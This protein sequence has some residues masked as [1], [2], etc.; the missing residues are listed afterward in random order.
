MNRVLFFSVFLFMFSCNSTE[1]EQTEVVATEIEALNATSQSLERTNCQ[2][3][4]SNCATV[5][6]KWLEYKTGASAELINEAIQDKFR[7]ELKSYAGR[8]SSIKLNDFEALAMSFIMDNTMFQNEFP[9]SNAEW[10]IDMTCEE[11]YQGAGI[12]SVQFNFNAYTGGAH[13]S[14]NTYYLVFDTESGS[15]LNLEDVVADINQLRTIA[16]ATFRKQKQIDPNVA[17]ED[18][19]YFIENGIFPVEG[20]FAI[21]NDSLILHYN[22]YDL[23]A[24]SEGKISIKIALN[25]LRKSAI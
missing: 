4:E 24:Y 15:V 6:L 20:N 17:L 23:A 1:T 8:D 14:E 22:A 13:G 7:N 25:E 16:E 12:L 3:G 10:Y 19:G 5:E 11:A 9:G 21:V 2:E 18:A